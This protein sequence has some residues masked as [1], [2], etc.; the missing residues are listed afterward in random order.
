MFVYVSNKLY[1][2]SVRLRDMKDLI[3]EVEKLAGQL[4]FQWTGENGMSNDD[5]QNAVLEVMKEFMVVG[6]TTTEDVKELILVL[7][8]L[9]K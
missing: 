5:A 6:N 1:I 4:V 9:I 7:K 2:S 3:K 8:G